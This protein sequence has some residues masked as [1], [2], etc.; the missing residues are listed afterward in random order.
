MHVSYEVIDIVNSRKR[1]NIF[2]ILQPMQKVISLHRNLNCWTAAITKKHRK[3]YL[4]TFP[5]YL[6]LPD[7]SSINID[8]EE[9]RRIITLPLNLDNV[10]EEERQ[11][12]LGKR[13]T[14]VKTK[15][16]EEYQDDFD[17]TQ[18]YN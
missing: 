14:I 4:N 18:F 8:Y 16:I 10:S 12:R 11:I 15:I 5:V 13:K 3:L 7:G 17:E 1:M 6:V 9:P 2:S